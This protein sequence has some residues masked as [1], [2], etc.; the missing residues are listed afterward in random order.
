[1]LGQSPFEP[2]IPMLD[3]ALRFQKDY[4]TKLIAERRAA[5]RDDFADALIALQNAGEKLSED[6][7]VWAL[8]FLLL[9]GHDTTRFTLA[10]CFHSLITWD[11]WEQVAANPDTIPDVI[12][13][14]MRYRPGTPR[15]I[16]VVKEP[17]EIDGHQLSVGDVVSLNLSAAGRDPT[18]FEN[19]GEFRCGR[20][21]G[22]LIGFGQGRHVCIGQ[23]LAKTEMTEAI[24]VVTAAL[25]DVRLAG[26]CAIKPTGVIAGID[27]LPI[28]FK[29]RQG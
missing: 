21:P 13:E 19:P 9:G 24:A 5:P 11:L 16:R 20:D 28:T 10:G 27:S 22:Y 29:P 2:G 17:W 26:E 12:A 7:L 6:E 23:L 8:V 14:S 25:T 15:Q 1:M 18:R 4:M 3:A